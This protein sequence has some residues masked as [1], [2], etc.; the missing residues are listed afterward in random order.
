M[1]AICSSETSVDIQRTALRYIPD[2]SSLHNHCCE[3]LES[4][5]FQDMKSVLDLKSQLKH[6]YIGIF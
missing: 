4:Y 6:I 3:N 1:E 5:K 2:N